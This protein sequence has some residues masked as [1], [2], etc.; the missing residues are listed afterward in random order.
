MKKYLVLTVVL[1]MLVG[2]TISIQNSAS[3]GSRKKVS[4]AP[5]VVLESSDTPVNQG[6]SARAIT[7]SAADARL[8][9]FGNRV[10]GSL[11]VGDTESSR[12]TELNSLTEVENFDAVAVDPKGN[13]YFADSGS[14]QVRVVSP[15]GATLRVLPI[16]QPYALS[17]LSNGNLVVASNAGMDLLHLY[18]PSGSRLLSF[19]DMRLFDDKNYKQNRF[20]NRGRI[21]IGPSDTIY[22]ISKNAPRPVV[23]KYSSDGSFLSEFA[24][25]GDAVDVQ[26]GFEETFLRGKQPTVVG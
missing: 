19:G 1:L 22:Y 14:N 9:Y 6:S 23:Q 20:L 26:L 18:S 5:L 4:Q 3:A 13:I 21:A 10:A 12:S 8:L 11:A 24:I 25:S 7:V 16:A 15:A 2:L 17:V